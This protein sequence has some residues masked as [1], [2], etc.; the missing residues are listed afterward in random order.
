[1]FG[2]AT[3]LALLGF[4]FGVPELTRMGLLVAGLDLV[5]TV[6]Q[7]L[8]LGRLLYRVYAVV[9]PRLG[10]SPVPLQGRTREGREEKAAA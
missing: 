4:A 1:M 9:A 8:R 6:V 7:T 2:S 10:M 5:V 3:L